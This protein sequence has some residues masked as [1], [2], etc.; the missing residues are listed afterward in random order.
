VNIAIH[1]T[2]RAAGALALAFSRAGHHIVSVSGRSQTHRDVLLA[3]I[4]VVPGTPDIRVI[5]VSDDAI[6]SVASRIAGEEHPTNTVHVSGAVSVSALDAIAS[7]GVQVGSFHPLQTLPNAEVGAERLA[8]SFIGITAPQPLHGDLVQLSESLGCTAFALEDDIKPLY[9]AAAAAAANFTLAML[10][11]SQDLFESADIPFE[12]A[13]PLVNAIVA[14]AFAL[15]PRQ[16]LTGP[17][18]RGD[19]ST[20]A[21]QLDAVAASNPDQLEDFKVL[22]AVTARAAG[23]SDR[24][25]GLST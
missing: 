6:E 1:G 12:A 21:K 3:S 13:E 19:V 14:N 16:A 23:T 7:S 11:L 24:F 20:V 17:I 2:G 18:A 22:V 15:G 8:G 10:A 9:H 25:M 4:A 5:A